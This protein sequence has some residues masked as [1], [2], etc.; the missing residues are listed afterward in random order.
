MNPFQEKAIPLSQQF[1]NWRQLYPK[2]YD[3]NTVD[4]YT[5]CRIILMNG[6]EFEANWFSHNFSRHTSDND[7]RR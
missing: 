1:Q 7:L 5:K 3:K 6:T 4:P 2:P